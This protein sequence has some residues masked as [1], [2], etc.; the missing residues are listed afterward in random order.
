[1]IATILLNG[2]LG[3]ATVIMLLFCIGSLDVL[4]SPT[5]YDFIAVFFNATKSHAGTSVLAAIPSA[6]C[7]CAAFGFLASSSRLTWAFARDRGVPFSNFLSH[8]RH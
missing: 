8:V 5:G 4:D 6:M 2:S 3:F 7:A 1:M